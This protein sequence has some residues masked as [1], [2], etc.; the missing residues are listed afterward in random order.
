M[1]TTMGTPRKINAI[2]LNIN[3]NRPKLVNMCRYKLSTYWQNFTEIHLTW[4][5]ILQ[6]FLGGL[7]FLTRTVYAREEW[8]NDTLCFTPWA[9]T[10]NWDITISAV[11]HYSM[12]YVM[13]ILILIWFVLSVLQY[14]IWLP[15]SSRKTLYFT[16]ILSLLLFTGPAIS[17]TM[18]RPC[19]KYIRHWV[20][21]Q[22]R[23][24]YSVVLPIPLLM[25]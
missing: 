12:L 16:S 17:Q 19:Q 4:V 9:A 22:S 10:K 24:I 7:L 2:L 3:I 20:L 1:L 14:M 25:G 11:I 13:L 15:D 8:N 23:K 21:G 6:K 5:K 18:E